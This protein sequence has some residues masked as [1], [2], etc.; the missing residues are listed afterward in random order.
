MPSFQLSA[1]QKRRCAMSS[2]FYLWSLVS[3][4]KCFENTFFMGY[5][6]GKLVRQFSISEPSHFLAKYLH[7]FLLSFKAG[8]K[9]GHFLFISGEYLDCV[10]EMEYIWSCLFHIPLWFFSHL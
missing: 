5:L 1:S 10:K 4:A 2:V 9:F 7:L 3:I 6:Q 8:I